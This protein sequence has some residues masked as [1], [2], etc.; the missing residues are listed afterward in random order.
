MEQEWPDRCTYRVKT[1]LLVLEYWCWGMHL[2]MHLDFQFWRWRW[3]LQWQN[4][5][6]L[7]TRPDYRCCFETTDILQN[8]RISWTSAIVH[9]SFYLGDWQGV[10]NSVSY[11]VYSFVPSEAY[12]RQSAWCNSNPPWPRNSS[13][14]CR[15]GAMKKAH[16]KLF[17]FKTV[18]K[19]RWKWCNYE[20]LISIFV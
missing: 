9:K 20:T 18:E 19:F 15:L 10:S 13:S 5:P 2:L 4:D 12:N 14:T 7:F 1:N 17:Q 8:T 11:L 16:L 6:S 3:Q